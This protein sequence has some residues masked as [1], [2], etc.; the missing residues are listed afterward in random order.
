[1]K[2]KGWGSVLLPQQN[3]MA[4]ARGGIVYQQVINSLASHSH[5]PACDEIHG[6]KEQ[7]GDDIV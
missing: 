4:A 2:N 7:D 3:G 6:P 1:M 5:Q